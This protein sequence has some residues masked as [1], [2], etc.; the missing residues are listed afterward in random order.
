M[1]KKIII[2][3]GDRFGKLKIIEETEINGQ[4]RNL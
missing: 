4:L 1:G 3:K 2:K